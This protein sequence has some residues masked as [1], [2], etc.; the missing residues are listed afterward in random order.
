MVYCVRG[1][2]GVCVSEAFVFFP[3]IMAGIWLGFFLC[4]SSYKVSLR[5]TRG[6]GGGGGGGGLQ[7]NVIDDCHQCK[8][9]VLSHVSL[10]WSCVFT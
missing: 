4:V 8:K 6:G 1:G 3:A 10:V 7:I 9:E 5:K 2:V